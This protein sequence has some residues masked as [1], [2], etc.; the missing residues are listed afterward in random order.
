[1]TPCAAFSGRYPHPRQSG[2]GVLEVKGTCAA[3]KTHAEFSLYAS[4]K[5]GRW[6]YDGFGE[7]GGDKALANSEKMGFGRPQ[8][9]PCSLE[10][11]PVGLLSLPPV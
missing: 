5:A 2:G 8:F 10:L 3:L 4:T 11:E 6:A 1:V 7:F 9:L